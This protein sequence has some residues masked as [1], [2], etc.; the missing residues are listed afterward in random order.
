MKQ[1]SIGLI[2]NLIL[3][4]VL[5]TSSL[6]NICLNEEILNTQAK[7]IIQGMNS[8]NSEVF[9]FLFYCI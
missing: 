3:A 6:A 1:E 5:I 9:Y 2:N 8:N 7:V 4:S